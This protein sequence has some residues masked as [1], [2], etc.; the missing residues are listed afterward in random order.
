VQKQG[1]VHIESAGVSTGKNKKMKKCVS[2]MLTLNIAEPHFSPIFLLKL[3]YKESANTESA[4]V[5]TGSTFFKYFFLIYVIFKEQRQG[6]VKRRV[7]GCLHRYQR[8]SFV[9]F[10]F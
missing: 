5:S 10:V 2:V 6:R 4:G 1:K 7:C 9:T 8:F 3:V